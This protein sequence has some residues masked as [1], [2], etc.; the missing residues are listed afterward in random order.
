MLVISFDYICVPEN[1]SNGY[2][3]I[4]CMYVDHYDLYGF[5]AIFKWCHENGHIDTICLVSYFVEM[6][7]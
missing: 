3:D 1:S 7:I 6:S 2:I 5:S 4:E